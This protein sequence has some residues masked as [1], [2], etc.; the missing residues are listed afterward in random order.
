[1]SNPSGRA[2]AESRPWYLSVTFR[3]RDDQQNFPHLKR[4]V[5]AFLDPEQLPIHHTPV[6]DSSWH[7]TVFAILQINRVSRHNESFADFAT[8]LLGRLT[9]QKGFD[10]ALASKFKQ[11]EALVREVRCYD[12]GTTVQFH[13]NDHLE[14][15]RNDLRGFFRD[16][17]SELVAATV[18]AYGTPAVG[19]MRPIVESLLDE[20]KKSCG[21]LLFG[22]IARSAC[23]SDSSVLR[24]KTTIDSGEVKLECR[25]LRLLVS[26]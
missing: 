26:D 17:V 19:W 12:D 11:F 14:V 3:W 20:E 7:S 16:R 15:L 9:K 8:F 18:S 23:R 24:W 2:P 22:S 10:E 21:K 4:T 5:E 13:D 6:P 25:K 1:M